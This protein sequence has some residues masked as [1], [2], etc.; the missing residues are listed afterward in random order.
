MLYECTTNF[1]HQGGIF[2]NQQYSLR[3]RRASRAAREPVSASHKLLIVGGQIT[4]HG[5]IPEVDEEVTPT[6][7]LT[8]LRLIHKDLPALIKQQY[9]TE[10]CSKTLA[11][12]KPEISQALDSL[13]NEV[14]STNESKVLRTAFCNQTKHPTNDQ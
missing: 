5:D 8:W 4:H 9:G 7:V 6:L 2:S 14:Y 1:N 12:L 11:S 3:A 13:L 10:L